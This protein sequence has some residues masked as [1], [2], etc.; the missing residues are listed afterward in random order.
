MTPPLATRWLARAL[1]GTNLIDRA[2]R[3][4][5]GARA[6]AVLSRA[7]PAFYDAYNEVCY[8][9]QRVYQASGDGVRTGFFPWEAQVVSRH[10][11]PPPARI[12]VGAAGGG[13]EAFAL[14]DRGY[15]VVAFEPA[16]A[17]ARSMARTTAPRGSIQVLMGRY[18]QLPYL[19]PV[20]SESPAIDVATLGPFDAVML[21]WASFS[22]LRSD[23]QCVATLGHAARL[24]TGPVFVSYFSR[25]AGR[26]GSEHAAE[27]SID[28]GYYRP[29]NE[30]QV[31]ALA[32]AAGLRVADED[33]YN[34]WSVLVRQ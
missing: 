8:G 16:A 4:F 13:R 27:F 31:A 25:I 21:G 11:P 12:L 34:G 17:L 20:P 22:H 26:N 28:L 1:R 2:Y 14:A 3:W 9:G 10:F 29:M 18:E 7:S 6:R 24:T 32:A 15:H 5:I 19:V 23:E 33:H 30:G